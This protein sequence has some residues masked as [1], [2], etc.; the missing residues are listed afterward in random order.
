VCRR[1]DCGKRTLDDVVQLC[2]QH[3]C[4]KP[5]REV[6]VSRKVPD[7]RWDPAELPVA[8]SGAWA[9]RAACRDAP[10]PVDFFAEG[11]SEAV[12]QEIEKAKAICEGC[13]ARLSCLE[14]GLRE[15]FGVWDGLDVKERE[16]LRK[17][18]QAAAA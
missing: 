9:D 18:R 6:K 4:H 14:A 12:L 15:T 2:A 11:R 1:T 5:R 10:A 7:D 17:S 3:R 16:K 8:G 13:P